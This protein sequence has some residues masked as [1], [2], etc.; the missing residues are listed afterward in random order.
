LV[1]IFNEFNSE[2][3]KLVDGH[4]EEVPH[5]WGGTFRW[6]TNDNRLR[7]VEEPHTLEVKRSLKILSDG[8]KGYAKE[9]KKLTKHRV[10]K[11][12]WLK[13]ALSP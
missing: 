8:V 11:V 7:E 2:P 9:L 3:G 10:K 12:D 13:T 1:N 5:A 4:F 6:P